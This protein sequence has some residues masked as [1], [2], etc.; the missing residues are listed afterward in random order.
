MSIKKYFDVDRQQNWYI[1]TVKRTK[2][3]KDEDVDTIM[4]VQHLG[5]LGIG[6]IAMM[7]DYEVW[8]RCLDSGDY[9]LYFK[10]TPV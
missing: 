4:Q 9:D 6:V 2:N 7:L 3:K 10:V 8:E 5:K 1:L